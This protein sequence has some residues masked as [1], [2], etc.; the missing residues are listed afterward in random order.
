MI[1]VPAKKTWICFAS[2]LMLG[3]HLQLKAQQKQANKPN[4]LL[5]LTDD[6]GYADFSFMTNRLVPT[7]NI[8]RIAKQG[9]KFTNAYVTGAV[10]SPSRAGLLTGINQAEFGH[11]FNYIQGVK[12]NIEQKDFGIALDKKLVGNYLKPLGYTSGIV[13]KWHEG[14]SEAYQP[15]QR[16]FDYFW[17]FLWGSSPYYTGKAKLVLEDGVHIEADSIPYMTD[18]IGNKAVD[19]INHH[20]SDP[21]F[22]YVSFNAPHTPMQAKPEYLEKTIDKFPVK[23]RAINAAMTM[24]I[25]ENVG[26]IIETLRRNGQLDN[27]LIV[28]ANDNGGQ[29]E[30]SFADNYPLPRKG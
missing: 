19:F 1:K 6:A 17:G 2:L 13:G 22:L 30:A 7:P 16:G 29:I 9:V 4:I 15:N 18:A 14:F 12:Y 8:D 23:G 28:F 21:F 11:T 3:F 25:D 20:Q 26:K 5:L 24:S 27:T 10:C